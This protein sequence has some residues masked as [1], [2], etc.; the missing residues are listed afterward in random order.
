MIVSCKNKKQDIVIIPDYTKNHLQKSRLL[1]NI[2]EIRTVSYY[3]YDSISTPKILSSVTQYYSPDGFLLKVVTFNEDSELVSTQRIFYHKNATENYWIIADANGKTTDSC[4][5]EYDMNG[6]ITKEKRWNVDSLILTTTYKTDAVGN[7]MELKRNN[8]V[9]TLTNT[10]AYN[11]YGLVSRI[12]EFEP[13]GKLFKYITIEYDNYGD[14]VNR[15]VFRSNDNLLEYTYTQYND[16]GHLL[17]VIYENNMHQFR[18]TYTYG[19]HDAYGN[20]L[21]EKRENINHAIYMRKRE[22]IYY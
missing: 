17:K 4:K 6:F 10:I 20:W 7:V 13:T 11:S 2:K 16:K 14:E 8:N 21:M 1:G 5:Y 22:I 18:E 15:R 9:F 12:E 19:D 3:Q